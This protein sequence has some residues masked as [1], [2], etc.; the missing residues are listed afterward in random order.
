MIKVFIIDIIIN[1][2]DKLYHQKSLINTL[3]KIIKRKI[4]IIDVGTF[5]GEY[6]KLFQKNFNC[7]KILCFEGNRKTYL[8]AKKKL[9]DYKNVK[10]F[11][12]S[13]SSKNKYGYLYEY[14]KKSISSLQNLNANSPYYKQKNILID[15]TKVKRKKVKIR[16]LD[17]FI[18]YIKKI[19]LLKIDVEGHELEVLKGAKKILKNTN[20]LLIE[21]HN[22]DQYKNYSKNKIF[23]IIKYNNF[24]LVK[25]HSFPFMSWEDRIYLKNNKS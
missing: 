4:N 14:K 20:I 9:K 17:S 22:S 2:I 8:N 6:T 16:K 13:I 21:I 23:K 19:D 18:K 15:L 12:Y 25:I 3:K 10:I 24:R 1:I 7:K 11:N 5:E